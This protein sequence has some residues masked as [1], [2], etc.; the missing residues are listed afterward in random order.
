MLSDLKEGRGGDI[1]IYL[2][3]IITPASMEFVVAWGKR[4]GRDE[5]TRLFSGL[6]NSLPYLNVPSGAYLALRVR[7]C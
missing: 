5:E 1:V 6:T 7:V 2:I 3:I 4:G